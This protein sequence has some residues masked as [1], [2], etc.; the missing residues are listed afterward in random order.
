[1]HKMG[2]IAALEKYAEGTASQLLYLQVDNLRSLLANSPGVCTRGAYAVSFVSQQQP[3]VGAL[4][5]RSRR[6]VND[7]ACWSSCLCNSCNFSN[8]VPG[9][10]L[11]SSKQLQDPKLVNLQFDLLPQH[12]SAAVRLAPPRLLAVI[13]HLL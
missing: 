3:M 8:P 11:A 12:L 13:A 4:P 7:D 10:G 5:W 6:L 1:M 2:S 9:K